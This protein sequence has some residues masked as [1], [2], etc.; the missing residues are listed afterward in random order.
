LTWYI[1]KLN[2]LLFE[3][4]DVGNFTKN[5]DP[6]APVD[7][8]FAFEHLVTMDRLMRKTLLAMSLDDAPAGNL[9]VFEIAELYDG[10]SE[11]FGNCK[12]NSAIQFQKA[13]FFKTLFDTQEGPSLITPPFADLPSPFDRYFSNLASDVYQKIE[14]TV[15]DSIWVR[16]KVTPNGILVRD[17]E[18]SKE[19]TMPVSNFVGEVMRAYRNAHHGYFSADRV[20]RNRPS[21]FLFLVDGNLPVEISALPVLWWLAYLAN[22]EAMV[23]WK[24]LQVG[25]YGPP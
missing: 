13:E 6:E 21:R 8:V 23:G 7:P 2:R 22:P 12:P 16:S 1:D 17:Q 19:E 4:T 5:H 14:Q 9:M 25:A 15:L 18:L 20:S 3:L 11:R 24:Y 10:L